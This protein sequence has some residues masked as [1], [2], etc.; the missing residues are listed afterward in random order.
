MLALYMN[1][2]KRFKAKL[3]Y[4]SVISPKKIK[5]IPDTFSS[6]KIY[7]N[8]CKNIYIVKLSCILS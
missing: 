8:K 3:I 4:C 1:S 6:S 5:N 2:I 7:E